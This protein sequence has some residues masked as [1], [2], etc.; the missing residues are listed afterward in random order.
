MED[1]AGDEEVGREECL[2]RGEEKGKNCRV[3]Q[4]GREFREGADRQHERASEQR[5]TGAGATA[6]ASSPVQ[7][8]VCA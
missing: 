5:R 1:S 3:E 6:T 8:S 2:E 4:E 7:Q